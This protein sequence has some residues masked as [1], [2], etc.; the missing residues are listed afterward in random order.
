MERET[1]PNVASSGLFPYSAGKVVTTDLAL[2]TFPLPSELCSN[3]PNRLEMLG[4]EL[5]NT[6]A[7]IH[8]EIGRM[9]ALLA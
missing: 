6:I 2:R 4:S 7:Y 1:S 5:Y 8:P 3:H 9:V